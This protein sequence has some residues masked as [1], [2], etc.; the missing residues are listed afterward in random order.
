VTIRFFAMPTLTTGTRGVAGV[1]E[2]NLYACPCRLVRD[3]CAQLVM[4]A[5]GDTT[6]GVVNVMSA[7]KQETFFD[8][9][10][11]EHG[12]I[13]ERVEIS[14]RQSDTPFNWKSEEKQ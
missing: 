10:G 1:N 4:H 13:W 5:S 6:M 8:V 2:L 12:L 9:R 3:T 7:T 11:W 14:P